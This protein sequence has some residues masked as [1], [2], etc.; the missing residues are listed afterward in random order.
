VWGVSIAEDLARQRAAGRSIGAGSLAGSAVLPLAHAGGPEAGKDKVEALMRGIRKTM[1]EHVGVVR[2]RE[3][4][5]VRGW[6]VGCGVCVSCASSSEGASE[7]VC[8]I[9][10][11]G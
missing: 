5:G 9:M 4:E 8:M 10:I 11:K 7:F 2:R 1:W 6:R 3:G